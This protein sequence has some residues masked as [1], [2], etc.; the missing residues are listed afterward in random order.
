[1]TGI[2]F[3]DIVAFVLYREYFMLDT[4][5]TLGLST[6][7]AMRPIEPD[8]NTLK[9]V[10]LTFDDGPNENTNQLLEILD[11]YNAK[12]PLAKHRVT[13]YV[14]GNKLLEKK[15]QEILKRAYSSGHEIANHTWDHKSLDSQ[16]SS[17]IKASLTKTQNIIK[18]TIGISPTN[19]RPPYGATST[20][21]T[22]S[23]TLKQVLWD[24]DTNDWRHR[25][26]WKT[27]NTIKEQ[28]APN[29]VILMHD[30]H[31]ESVDSV[32]YI[33]ET[34]Q[35]QGYQSVTV[36]HLRKFRPSLK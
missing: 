10:A 5:V 12:N 29:K 7:V 31:K 8:C 1:L 16:N 3:D 21:V 36:S 27:L 15:N 26:K 17:G 11:K 33:L 24:I 32:P 30:I 18:S 6:Y 2:N 14:V 4:L 9:C 23:T 34:L 20:K 28:L 25:N 35:K 13:F 22:S 19:F